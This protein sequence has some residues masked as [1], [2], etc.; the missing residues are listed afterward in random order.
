M[1]GLDRLRLQPLGF[2]LVGP[3]VCDDR[4]E[5]TLYAG[6]AVDCC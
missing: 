5:A 6:V 1:T 2:A 3:V 4:I